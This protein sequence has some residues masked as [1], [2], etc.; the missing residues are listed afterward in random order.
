MAML[1]VFQQ[2][3]IA[4]SLKCMR[5]GNMEVYDT[6][7][8]KMAELGFTKKNGTQIRIK[9]KRLK[10]CYFKFKRGIPQDVVRSTEVMAMLQAIC[11]TNEICTEHN[12]STS[13]TNLTNNDEG[14]CA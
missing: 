7:A 13:V 8:K 9:W 12:L 11:D 1:E 3:N 5:K 4:Q 6:V 14:L 10:S 2:F